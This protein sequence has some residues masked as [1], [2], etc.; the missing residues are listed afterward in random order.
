MDDE[1]AEL[2]GRLSDALGPVPREVIENARAALRENAA[3]RDAE[4]NAAEEENAEA[5]EDA[6]EW[7]DDLN[8][9]V[10]DR[11]SA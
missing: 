8:D 10:H 7:S 2:L 6:E 3:R 4:E 1:Q 11:R 5:D 9:E